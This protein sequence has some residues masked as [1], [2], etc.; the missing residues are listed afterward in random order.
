MDIQTIRELAEKYSHAELEACIDAHVSEGKNVCWSCDS[1]EDTV[2]VLSKASYMKRLLES[3]KA[4][5][6]QEAMRVLAKSMR[7]I[8]QK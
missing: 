2:N 6:L 8:Q 3:G 1:A 4:G 7:S 5:N